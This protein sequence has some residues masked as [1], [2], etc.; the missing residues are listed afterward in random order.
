MKVKLSTTSNQ[1]FIYRNDVIKWTPELVK[2]I[3]DFLNRKITS[4]ENRENIK[5]P[6]Q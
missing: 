6:L 1:K 2:E 5:S 4:D 3:E